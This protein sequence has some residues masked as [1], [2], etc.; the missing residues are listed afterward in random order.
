MQRTLRYVYRTYRIECWS[1]KHPRMM[2]ATW[3]YK[4]DLAPKAGCELTLEAV[5]LMSA[6][7]NYH[8]LASAYDQ[9]TK[10]GRTV[11]DIHYSYIPPDLPP[12]ADGDSTTA[13]PSNSDRHVMT[14]RCSLPTGASYPE[15]NTPED[16]KSLPTA[17]ILDQPERRRN[18]MSALFRSDSG[19]P[20]PLHIQA[21]AR[22]HTIIHCSMPPTNHY[23]HPDVALSH[24]AIW[25]P[26]DF[27][28]PS[29]VRGQRVYPSSDASDGASEEIRS[30]TDEK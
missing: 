20:H 30:D 21:P 8:L 14:F 23:Q 2:G 12:L 24:L 6:M 16:R 13:L 3:Q 29:H 1:I 17:I 26:D 10:E 11:R 28:L 22:Y 4:K 18:A 5:D 25:L 9:N 27:E 15:G 7:H 19:D